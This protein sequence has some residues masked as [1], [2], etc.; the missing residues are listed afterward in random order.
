MRQRHLSQKKKT[1]EYIAA[2]AK[3]KAVREAEQQHMTT[4]AS[5]REEKVDRKEETL[6]AL[7]EKRK[8]MDKKCECPGERHQQ[9]DQ[10]RI[11]RQQKNKKTRD[12]AILE[13]FKGIKTIANTKT[14]K[15]DF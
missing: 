12:G 7:I 4:T 8:I 2:A 3:Q 6:K 13:Q 9:E 1:T 11:Q 15:K 5:Q 10:T 14:G